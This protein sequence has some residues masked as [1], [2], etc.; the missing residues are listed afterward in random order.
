MTA[1]AYNSPRNLPDTPEF[2]VPASHYAAVLKE[3]SPATLDP[4]PLTWAVLGYLKFHCRGGRLVV[5]NL[6]WTGDAI[7]AFSI[8]V[9]PRV[10][11]R[12]GTDQG[13]E[14]ALRQAYA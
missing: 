11:F 10:Y 2:T 13:I 4:H 12:G 7:G 3:L 6:F 9:R 5:V 8:G 14:D 1:M